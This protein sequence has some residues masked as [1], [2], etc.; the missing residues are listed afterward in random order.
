MARCPQNTLHPYFLSLGI[1]L[2]AI[3]P[4]QEM[5]IYDYETIMMYRQNR[6]EGMQNMDPHIFAIAEEAFTRMERYVSLINFLCC[7]LFLFSFV[8][9]FAVNA[10]FLFFGFA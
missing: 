1:V 5:P 7:P 6:G 8:I 4:Y 9:H 10:G 3:N 2:V